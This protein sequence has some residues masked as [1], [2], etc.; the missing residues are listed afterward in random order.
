MTKESSNP[1]WPNTARRARRRKD[2][3]I[4]YHTNDPGYSSTRRASPP[5]SSPPGP[6]RHNDFS[7]PPPS[8]QTANLGYYNTQTGDFYQESFNNVIHQHNPSSGQ[9]SIFS[10]MPYTLTSNSTHGVFN[11]DSQSPITGQSQ[12]YS[13]DQ[14]GLQWTEVHTGNMGD[15]DD[16]H[17]SDFHLGSFGSFDSMEMATRSPDTAS[18]MHSEEYVFP[19]TEP[20]FGPSGTT[21]QMPGLALEGKISCSGSPLLLGLPLSLFWRICQVS[22]G[23]YPK[24]SPFGKTDGFV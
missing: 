8:L 9:D 1:Q 13:N 6:T 24:L 3:K 4:V 18:S 5:A 16:M 20:T 15:I 12:L 23:A 7:Y 17:M 14:G 19:I 11:G 2:P 22:F 21:D 10:N